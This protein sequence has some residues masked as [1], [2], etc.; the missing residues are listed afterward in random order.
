MLDLFLNT[1]IAYQ[2]LLTILV[3]VASTERHFS[4]LKN[5]KIISKID[6]VSRKIK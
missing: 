2:I 5:N 6:N 1:C 4:K 3:T